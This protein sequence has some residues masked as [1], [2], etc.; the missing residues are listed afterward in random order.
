MNACAFWP[1]AVHLLPRL[2]GTMQDTVNAC[3]KS[4]HVAQAHLCLG[5]LLAQVLLWRQDKAIKAQQL[6]P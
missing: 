2:L 1:L 4:A 3:L 6:L 5:A